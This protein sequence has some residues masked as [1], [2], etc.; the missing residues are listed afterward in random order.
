M[1]ED[2]KKEFDEEIL[3]HNPILRI[4]DSSIEIYVSDESGKG[5]FGSEVTIYS[6][7]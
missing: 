6:K 4:G 2:C 3:L 7:F 1:N 5:L